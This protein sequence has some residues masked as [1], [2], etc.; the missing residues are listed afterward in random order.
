MATDENQERVSCSLTLQLI[1]WRWDG[2]V[3]VLIE[4]SWRF[5]VQKQI[6]LIFHDVKPGPAL[7]G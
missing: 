2:V 6:H 4:G 3:V 1:V 5:E 7:I